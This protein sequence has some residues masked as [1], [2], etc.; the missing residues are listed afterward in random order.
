MATNT[1]IIVE[2]LLEAVFSNQSGTKLYKES[3][4]RKRCIKRASSN[5]SE[6]DTSAR[7]SEP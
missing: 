2:E 1:H 3:Q 7:Q 5:L 6:T 4:K